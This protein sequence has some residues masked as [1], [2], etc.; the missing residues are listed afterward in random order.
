MSASDE[1]LKF[2]E[3]GHVFDVAKYD[4]C[5]TCGSPVAGGGQDA[6]ATE[7]APQPSPA[8][9]DVAAGPTPV[10]PMAPQAAA[11]GFIDQLL[12]RLSRFSDTQKMYAGGG[13]AAVLV[14]AALIVL[15]SGGDNPDTVAQRDTDTDDQSRLVDVPEEDISSTDSSFDAAT[16]EPYGIWETFINLGPMNPRWRQVFE[17]HDDGTYIMHDNVYGHAGRMTITGRHYTLKS[18]TNVYEDEGIYSRP[19][20]DSIVFEGRLGRSVWTAVK[21]K[22][23]FELTSVAPQVPKDIPDVLKAMT[24]DAQA[25]WRPDAVAVNLEIERNK[26]TS[27]DIKASFWSPTDNAGYVLTWAPYKASEYEHEA[28]R[29]SQRAL[30]EK[31]LDLPQAYAELGQ[32]NVLNRATLRVNEN[33]IPVWILLPS[34]GQGGG[35]DAR[36]N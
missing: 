12:G 25:V 26:Y 17:I 18:R 23:L 36:L 16:A 13:V 32:K 29:W 11:P 19:D 4:A 1:D 20:P 8:A 9:S 7:T 6:P 33:S 5:P 10:A 28:V 22:P 30:P 14:V 34:Y 21:Q 15:L 24:L 27:Y 2:C 35:V 3:E 31:F